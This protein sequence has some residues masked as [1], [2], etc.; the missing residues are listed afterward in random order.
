MKPL[1]KIGFERIIPCWKC[2]TLKIHLKAECSFSLRLM[3][4]VLIWKAGETYPDSFTTLG[5]SFRRYFLHAYFLSR[6]FFK[7]LA[8]F[9]GDKVFAAGV[10]Q[11]WPL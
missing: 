8:Q 10:M 6:N 7:M 9:V 11:G 1:P 4:I 2:S 5:K 3:A